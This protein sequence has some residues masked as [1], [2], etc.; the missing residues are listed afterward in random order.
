MK[1][2]NFVQRAFLDSGVSSIENSPTVAGTPVIFRDVTTS[3]RITNNRPALSTTRTSL[4]A[5]M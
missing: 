5:S 3:R 1:P 2:A 4:K